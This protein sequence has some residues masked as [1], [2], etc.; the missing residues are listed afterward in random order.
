MSSNENNVPRSLPIPIGSRR[1]SGSLSDTSSSDSGSISPA[2]PVQ[3]PASGTLPRIN[4]P[5]SPS[6]SPI[7]S[8]FLSQ[9]PKSPAA[10]F[11]FRRGMAPPVY[12]DEVFESEKPA[13]RHARSASA[14]AW[15]AADKFSAP[16]AVPPPGHQQDRA[17]GIFRRLSLGGNMARP[18]IAV[19]KPANGH[20]QVA[21]RATTPPGMKSNAAGA[22]TT[23]AR[24]ARRANTMASGTPRPPRAPSPMGERI[25]KGHFDGFN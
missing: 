10:T 4:P 25:L 20:P 1:R 6:T 21:P 8:Y 2:S 14:A 5:I 24:K 19:P 11:P 15:P 22:T 23:P 7:L 16:P 12:E 9:S 13:Q 17:A 3:T 18:Q